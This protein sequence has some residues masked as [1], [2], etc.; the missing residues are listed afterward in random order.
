VQH[1]D[2]GCQYASD[3]Y[4]RL[5]AAHGMECNMSRK[6]NCWDDAP[7][8]SFFWSFK[9]K[10]VFHE[11]WSGITEARAA[12]CDCIEVFYSRERLH[13]TLGYITPMEADYGV[14]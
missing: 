4:R 2:R 3:D 5:L 10:L 7:T 11:S 8:E 12:T 9:Q 14:Q 13:S 6:G 1:S